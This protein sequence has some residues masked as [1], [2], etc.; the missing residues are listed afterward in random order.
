M[1]TRLHLTA[2]AAVFA[3]FTPATSILHAQVRRASEGMDVPDGTRKC[4]IPQE[5]APRPTDLLL[6]IGRV[7]AGKCS[8]DPS[9]R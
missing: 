9:A 8:T 1:N 5:R 6:V 7:K 3:L 2:L 4:I